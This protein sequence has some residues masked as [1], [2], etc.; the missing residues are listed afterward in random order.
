VRVRV[1]VTVR[2][3]CANVCERV[4]LGVC[5]V[6][7]CGLDPVVRK[8]AKITAGSIADHRLVHSW[9]LRVYVCARV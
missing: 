2:V 6:R 8:N 5:G 4:C 1:G 7:V 9:F 3:A